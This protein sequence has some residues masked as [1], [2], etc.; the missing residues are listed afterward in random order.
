M[1]LRSKDDLYFED[2]LLVPNL[3]GTSAPVLQIDCE[4]TTVKSDRKLGFGPL[5]VQHVTRADSKKNSY[6][7]ALLNGVGVYICSQHIE[8]EFN[9]AGTKQKLVENIISNIQYQFDVT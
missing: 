1:S 3:K 2:Q 7:T 6:K 8:Q 4:Q 5:T 9:L